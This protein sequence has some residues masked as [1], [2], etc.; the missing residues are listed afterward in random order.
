MVSTT[1]KPPSFDETAD[2]VAIL[3]KWRATGPDGVLNEAFKAAPLVMVSQLVSMLRKVYTGGRVPSAWREG[4]VGRCSNQ[5]RSVGLETGA[6]KF[7][8]ES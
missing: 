7:S 5:R 8:R 3:P 4:W 2:V 1:C 6:S